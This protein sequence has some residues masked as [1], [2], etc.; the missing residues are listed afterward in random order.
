MPKRV[1]PLTDVQVRNAKPQDKPQRLYDGGGLYL[2][3]SVSGGKLWRLKY[4]FGGTEKLL[5]FGA[6]PHISLSD[7]RGRRD[8]AKKL[9]A[10]G[11]DPGEEKKAQK[12]AQTE[13]ETTF[14]M[15][16]REWYGKQLEVWSKGHADTVISRL[17]HDVFPF[18]GNKPISKIK[19]SEMLAVLKRVEGRGAVDTA[20]RIKI[21][22]GQVFRYAVLSD[23]VEADIMASIKP[24][25]IFQKKEKKHHAAITD[26]KLLPP[27]LRA[28]DE[29]HGSFVIKSALQ[30]A[31]L[32][33]V[34]PGELQNAVWTEI[35]FEECLWNIPAERM[36]MKKPHL[37]PLCD[38]AISVLKELHRLTGHSKYVFPGRTYSRPMSNNTINAALRYMGFDKDTMTGHGFRATARTILD[39]VLQVRPDFVEHQLAHAVKDPNGRA[40]NR[41]AHLVERRKMMQLWA[42]YLDGLK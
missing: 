14:E 13:L 40:Y 31:P 7:A 23:K 5:S 11:I 20:L 25:E 36:K 26:P 6:Y 32:L 42:D 41:T 28:I 12:A 10:N 15:V 39:E 30:L 16:A 17:E 1:L 8:D 38:Q 3:I 2:Q 9:I 37:V 33:F 21:I 24:R 22:C 27:L 35:D 18:V 19:T 29:Y 4:C 34:R